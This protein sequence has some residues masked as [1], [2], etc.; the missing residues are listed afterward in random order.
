MAG[1]RLLPIQFKPAVSK[2][3]YQKLGVHYRRSLFV[4]PVSPGAATF[5]QSLLAK[6]SLIAYMDSWP[7]GNLS[8]GACLIQQAN[9]PSRVERY[10]SIK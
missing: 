1:R 8:A 6:R 5:E 4:Q 9:W 2:I 7:A 3:R 10:V